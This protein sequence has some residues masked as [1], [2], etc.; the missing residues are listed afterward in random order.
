MEKG[1]TRPALPC[2]VP[3]RT[4]VRRWAVLH[5]NK[6]YAFLNCLNI[7]VDFYLRDSKKNE[8]YEETK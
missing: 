8:E 2:T 1:L 3:S 4:A 7:C 6:K 5:L